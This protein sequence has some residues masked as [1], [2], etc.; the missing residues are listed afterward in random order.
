MR[1]LIAGCLVEDAVD[2]DM[3][4]VSENDDYDDEESASYTG[5]ISLETQ[6]SH[7]R[8][9]HPLFDYATCSWHYHIR[10]SENADHDQSQVNADLRRFIGDHEIFQAWLRLQWTST[11]RLQ[12]HVDKL[13]VTRLHMAARYGLLSYSTELIRHEEV[14]ARDSQ[15]RTPL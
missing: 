10:A 15:G 1:Y 6:I 4:D 11:V 12:R 5:E 14:D 13:R 9:K 2:S 8:Q 3:S 7:R